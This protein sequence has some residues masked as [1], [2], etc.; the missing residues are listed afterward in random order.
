MKYVV[1]DQ[2]A[3]SKALE[4]PLAAYLGS[5]AEFISAQAY[6]P[7]PRRIDLRV[8]FL[9]PIRHAGSA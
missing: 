8:F 3:L 1:C 5:F 2:V 6:I 4:G 7:H 9:G